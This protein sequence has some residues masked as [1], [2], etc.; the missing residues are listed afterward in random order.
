MAEFRAPLFC[1]GKIITLP[2]QGIAFNYCS[3]DFFQCLLF[4]SGS[5]D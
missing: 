5:L 4:K 1:N 3:F 2:D